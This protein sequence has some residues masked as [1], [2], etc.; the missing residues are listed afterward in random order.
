MEQNGYHS[1]GGRETSACGVCVCVCVC[2]CV[3]FQGLEPI[4]V[5]FP[6]EG[7][8]LHSQCSSIVCSCLCRG[9]LSYVYECFPACMFEH[10]IV[11][12]PQSPEE[13]VGSSGTGVTLIIGSHGCWEL[14]QGS[15]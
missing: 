10:H 1:A 9:A 6:G 7:I 3:R 5:L 8:L 4:R 11:K 12:F 15:A 2:V 13:G 14:N